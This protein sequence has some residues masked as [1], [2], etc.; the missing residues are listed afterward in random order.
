VLLCALLGLAPI[1]AHPRNPPQAQLAIAVGNCQPEVAAWA[2]GARRRGGAGD[3]D[4]D[5]GGEAQ[6]VHL[7]AAGA[8]AAAGILEGLDALGFLD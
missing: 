4:G 3:G 1:R 8:E 7:A 2:S 6:R 5:G